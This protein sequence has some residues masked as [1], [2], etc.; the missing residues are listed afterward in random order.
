MKA[1]IFDKAPLSGEYEEKYFGKSTS[2][3][4]VKFETDSYEKWVGAFGNGC[5]GITKV[6]THD[7]LVFVVAKGSVYLINRNNKELIF[8]EDNWDFIESAIITNNPDFF[9]YSTCF[10]YKVIKNGVVIKMER[11]EYVDGI[12]FTEQEGGFAVGWI[13]QIHQDRFYEK[14]YLDLNTFKLRIDESIRMD[15]MNLINTKK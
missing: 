15:W 7:D 9:I 10:G 6:I 12:L 3:L 14:M 1:I 13:D 2:T 8:I 5:Y 11:P 4:W